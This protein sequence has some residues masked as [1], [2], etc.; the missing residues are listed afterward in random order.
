MLYKNYTALKRCI[1]AMNLIKLC[2]KPPIVARKP[3]LSK[4]HPEKEIATLHR[5][6]TLKNKPSPPQ[7]AGY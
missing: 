7:A 4:Y 6:W 1:I 2:T 5:Q 3:F